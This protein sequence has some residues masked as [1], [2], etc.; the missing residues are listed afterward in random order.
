MRWQIHIIHPTTSASAYF[1]TCDAMI[2]LSRNVYAPHISGVDTETH[3]VMTNGRHFKLAERFANELL[4]PNEE[5]FVPR[6]A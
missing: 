1:M 3:Q 6:P 4:V 2:D 5:I